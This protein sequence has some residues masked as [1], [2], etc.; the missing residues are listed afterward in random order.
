MKVK[1]FIYIGL[2]LIAGVC[3]AMLNS[4]GPEVDPLVK[5]IKAKELTA[6]V[7]RYK[8]DSLYVEFTELKKQYEVDSIDYANHSIINIKII[9]NLNKKINEISFKGYSNHK[10][11]S[12]IV[13]LYG[14]G[15]IGR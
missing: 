11:D 7:L 5:S 1:D 3:G 4:R 2:I 9:K 10:L 6:K 12:L 13:N 15:S 14:E 8:Y